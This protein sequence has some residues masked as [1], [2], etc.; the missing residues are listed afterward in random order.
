MRRTMIA[1]LAG[2]L[3]C[4]SAPE[5]GDPAPTERRQVFEH[6]FDAASGER[7][8]VDM[9]PGTYRAETT[10]GGVQLRFAPMQSGVQPA[11]IRDLVMGRTV[12]GGG[13]WE[14]VV[15]AAATYEIQVTGGQPGGTTV[16]RIYALAPSSP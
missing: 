5:P 13:L 7:V 8:R 6:N 16:L 3:A 10:D 12:T 15:H 9:T 4:A 1:A 11:T 2:V 14:V